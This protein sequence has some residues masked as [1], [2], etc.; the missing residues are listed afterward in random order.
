[1]SSLARARA[2]LR[3]R[4]AHAAPIPSHLLF[5]L[6]T[7]NSHFAAGFPEELFVSTQLITHKTPE[8]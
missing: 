8:Q 2:Y 5:A 7:A 1:M 3:G 6:R 4:P